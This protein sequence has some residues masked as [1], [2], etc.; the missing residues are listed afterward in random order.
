MGARCAGTQK[1]DDATEI[2]RRILL[3]FERA[4]TETDEARRRALLTFVIIGGGPTGVEMAGAI[5]ELAKKALLRDFRHIDPASARVILVEAGPRILPAFP[6]TLSRFAAKSLTRMGVE[7]QTGHAATDCTREGVALG[8]SFIGARTIIWAA[9]VMASPAA[10]W[11]GLKGDRAGRVMV[12]DHLNAASDRRIFVVG[13]TAAVEWEDGKYVPGIAPAA[14]QMGNYAARS[15]HT[16]IAGKTPAAFRYRH[17]GNLATIGRK[18]A[19]IDFGR[20]EVKG[21]IA[22]LLWGAA[23]V[24]FLIGFRNRLMVMLHWLWAYVSFRQDVRLITG[25]T[26][27]P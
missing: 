22:W 5:I 18:S 21:F 23:H 9:G 26:K 4:E 13:D 8:E 12:D 24:Y 10:K 19:V 27:L 6:E 2:R 20:L 7:I 3:A 11:L 17:Q 1:I 25:S 14:K 16:I 15:I